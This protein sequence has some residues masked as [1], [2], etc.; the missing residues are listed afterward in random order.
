MQSLI[1]ISLIKNCSTMHL[2]LVFSGKNSILAG[3]FLYSK[4]VYSVNCWM[5]KFVHSHTVWVI[6]QSESL[7]SLSHYL[8]IVIIQSESLYSLSHYTV[9]VIIQFEWLYSLGDYTEVIIQFESLYSLG[10][11]TVWVIMLSLFYLLF[12]FL[13]L[14]NNNQ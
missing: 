13:N 6:I 3:H 14:K 10:D 1:G 12:K 4:P 9:W 8:V 11:Y 2:Q 7:Y 5:Q